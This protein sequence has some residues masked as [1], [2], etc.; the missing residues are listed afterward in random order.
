MCQRGMNL[1]KSLQHCEIAKNI[2]QVFQLDTTRVKH[3]MA[4]LFS[5]SF[6]VILF[7]V[8]TPRE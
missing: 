8:R 4:L 1:D 7:N 3:L 2:Q 6:Y 5:Y